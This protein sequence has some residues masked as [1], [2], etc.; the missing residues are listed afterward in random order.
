LA[1][2]PNE[3]Y[4]KNHRVGSFALNLAACDIKAKKIGIKNA[5]QVYT[6]SINKLNEFI[7]KSNANHSQFYR[8]L[9]LL[10]HG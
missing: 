7:K 9:V 2:P 8:T 5:G 3:S 4:V 10:R 6:Q 1:Y